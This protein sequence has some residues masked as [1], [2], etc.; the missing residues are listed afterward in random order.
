MSDKMKMI[1]VAGPFRAETTWGV[2]Q[3]IRR[4]EEVVFD[5][6]KAAFETVGGYIALCPHATFRFS[7]GILSE[8]FWLGATMELMKRC[9]AIF[10]MVGHGNSQG[11]LAEL[12]EATER[13][14][15]VFFQESTGVADLHYWA[16][17]S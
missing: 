11:S 14:M 3:N 9:D 6:N 17:L 10:M 7:D 15:K 16:E 8:E 12:A 4:A 1:Y 2:E 5:L 13:G